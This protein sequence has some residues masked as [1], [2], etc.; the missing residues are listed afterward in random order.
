MAGY[1]I[2]APVALYGPRGRQIETSRMARIALDPRA[3]AAL[4]AGQDVGVVREAIEQG[5]DG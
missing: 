4:P 3:P 1:G 5:G 2:G